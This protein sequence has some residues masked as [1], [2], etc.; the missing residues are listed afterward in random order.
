MD[1]GNQLSHAERLDDVVVGP[2]SQPDQEVGLVFTGREHHYRGAPLLLNAAAYLDA[3]ELRQHDVQHH[4]VGLHRPASIDTGQ[5][6]A[7]DLGREALTLQPVGYRLRNVGL[8][9]DDED[10]AGHV[11]SGYWAPGILSPSRM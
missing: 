9:F 8:V 1:A 7:T 2:D 6:L 10:R 11:L 4:Q 5:S 3:V